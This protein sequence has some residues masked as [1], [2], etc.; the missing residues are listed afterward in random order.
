MTQTAAAPLNPL[1]TLDLHIAD[2]RV[3]WAAL[4]HEQ[5]HD[6][7]RGARQRIEDIEP[8]EPTE[9]LLQRSLMLEETARSFAPLQHRYTGLLKDA[10]DTPKLRSTVDLPKGKT[11][12][13]DATDML[14][15]THGIRAYEASGR[16]KIA[17]AMTP[18][19]ASDPERDDTVAVGETKLPILG[20]IQ[21]QGNIHPSK[22]SSALNMINAVDQEAEAA[23]KDQEYR[24]NLQR[25]V[26]KDLAGRIGAT[27]PEE[28]S[29]YV[30]NKKKDILASID[31][32]DKKFTQGQTDAMHSAWC[33]GTVRG[34]QNAYKWVIITDAEGNEAFK[35]IE[36]TA[37][38]PRAK[39]DDEQE[40][41]SR[42]RGQRSM[43]AF[44]D[45]IKFALANLSNSDLRGAN[46]AHTQMVVMADYP[47][48]M[49]GVRRELAELLPDIEAEQ[50]ERLLAML[51]EAELAKEIGDSPE[52]EDV[53][54]GSLIPAPNARVTGKTAR[55]LELD[56][57]VVTLPPPKTPDISAIL[58]DDNLDRLQ[59]RISQG[60]YTPYMPPDAL[61]RMLCDVSVSPVTLTGRR[62]VLSIGRKQRKFSESIRRAILARD[63]GCTVPGCHWP[64]AWCELHHVIPW[65]QDGETSVENGTLMCSH[66]HQA[67]HAKMLHIERVDGEIQFRLHPLLDPAQQP[68]KNYFWQS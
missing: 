35:T 44:R 40:F 47:T 65:S 33:E 37:N 19:R 45:A 53:E 38:N 25:L 58:H 20:A 3:D 21:A 59:P 16:T 23:G 24:D 42:T 62:Q 8:R 54:N 6:L 50:R 18:K 67:L 4:S 36:A 30:S 55:E 52:D 66:H 46:G 10:F 34:N 22:L 49:E 41:D 9:G 61:L 14:A 68:R 11:P 17:V 27:S 60:I 7:I 63:R 39:D 1:E 5:L 64:A 48:L 56:G 28:F 12:F 31:P 29:H 13:R 32:A 2:G 26:E 57:E 15:K 51:A 43:H